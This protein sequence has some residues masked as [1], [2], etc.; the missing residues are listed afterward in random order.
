MKRLHPDIA[1]HRLKTWPAPFEAVWDGLKR[2][3]IR[4]CVDRTYRVGDLLDLQEYDPDARTFSGRGVLAYVT[5]MTSGSEWGLPHDLCVL[6]LGYLQTYVQT[7]P[8]APVPRQSE[9]ST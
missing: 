4:R 5:Y 3:E 9:E 6:S 2:Y 8:N 7:P 1:V